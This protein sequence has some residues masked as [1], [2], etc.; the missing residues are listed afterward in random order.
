[1]LRSSRG[2][3]FR[4]CFF[5]RI[6]AN[7]ETSVDASAVARLFSVLYSDPARRSGALDLVLA[8]FSGDSPHSRPTTW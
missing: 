1:M 3:W 4:I 2:S 8:W 5:S 7:T 6:A